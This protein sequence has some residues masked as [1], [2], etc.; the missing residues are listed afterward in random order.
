MIFAGDIYKTVKF[1]N[2]DHLTGVR[3]IYIKASYNNKRYLA[4][5][6]ITGDGNISFTIPDEALA[7]PGLIVFQIETDFRTIETK[8]M[9]VN[10]PIKMSWDSYSNNST[11]LAEPKLDGMRIQ[12]VKD[13]KLRLLRENGIDKTKHFPEVL[14]QINNLPE[15]TILDGEICILENEF[16]ADFQ[17]LQTRPST[18]P[19]PVP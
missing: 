8:Q 10:K 18:K 13:N 9:V 12:V 5:E 2:V 7:E 17:K 6:L 15:D 14:K 3:K 11:F 4:K 19:W 1:T 16:V